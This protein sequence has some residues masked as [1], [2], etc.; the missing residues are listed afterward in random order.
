MTKTKNQGFT[1][2][3]LLIVIVVIAILASIS[4]VSYTGV[5]NRANDAAVQTDLRNFISNIELVKLDSSTGSY[6]Y[7]PTASMNFKFTKSAYGM[8][9]DGKT[10][11]YCSNGLD[12]YVLYVRSKSGNFFTATQG[13][14]SKVNEIYGGWDVCSLANQPSTNPY[15][16]FD[17]TRSPQWA[18]WANN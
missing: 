14:I 13:K 10:V 4:I 7:T 9:S 12:S 1:I 3:E 16:G 11:K 5:Q 6:P 8:G 2:V 18:S 15:D 17:N